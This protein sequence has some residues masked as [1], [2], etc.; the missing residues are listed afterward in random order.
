MKYGQL[1]DGTRVSADYASKLNKHFCPGCGAAL[2]L[3]QG[4][5]NDW[6]F[7]HESGK[8][9]DAFT[10]NK[11]TEWH[12]MH[13]RDFPEEYREVRLEDPE[14]NE[15]HI[16]DIK[17]GNLIIEFQHSHIDNETF[18]NR[19]EFYSQ[20]GRVVWVFDFMDKW[21]DGKIWWYQKRAGGNGCFAWAYPNKM[22]GEYHLLGCGFDVFIQLHEDLYCLV[23]WNP[24]GMKFFN[25]RQ[26]NHSEFLE[27]LRNVYRENYGIRKLQPREINKSTGYLFMCNFDD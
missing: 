21:D 8:D 13:Q 3:K 17:C 4:P 27:Y 12:I 16:A 22:L 6:H 24:R 7:A 9:C 1:D 25:G 11:M 18:E 10:E 5:I 15:V 23:E 2:I 19:T 20:Y 26:F 14:C